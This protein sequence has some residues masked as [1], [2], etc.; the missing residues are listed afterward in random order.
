MK[1]LSFLKTCARA[2]AVNRGLCLFSLSSLA[3]KHGGDY[4]DALYDLLLSRF[5]AYKVEY[6]GKY[7]E[8]E[9]ADECADDRAAAA[10]QAVSAYECGGYAVRFK[11][12]SRQRLGG[13][14]SGNVYQGS[15]SSEYAAENVYKHFCFLRL[16]A[17]KLCRSFISA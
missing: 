17:R 6:V 13:G 15:K 16:D 9:H 11:A 10:K 4:Y 14:K 3:H 2:E 7:S 8:H 5:Q 1:N 12:L